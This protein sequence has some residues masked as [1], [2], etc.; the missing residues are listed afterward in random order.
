V[1][2]IAV[3]IVNHP[4][5]N[6]YGRS[7]LLLRRHYGCIMRPARRLTRPFDLACGSHA[8]IDPPGAALDDFR[9]R[10]SRAR[11]SH[12]GWLGNCCFTGAVPFGQRSAV[13]LAVL[14]AQ[15]PRKDFTYH[16]LHLKLVSA[17]GI[18]FRF[19][20]DRWSCTC[21]V[22]IP[23][24]TTAD[25]GLVNEHRHQSLEGTCDRRLL[26]AGLCSV[27][28]VGHAAFSMF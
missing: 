7:P 9:S 11:W 2:S 4:H 10:R 27:G 19:T 20:I 17:C 14:P 1:C 5:P 6:G 21:H 12:Q 18:E 16:V 8:G 24:Y 25:H 28:G 26:Y 22:N 15:F 13:V 23:W 3:D